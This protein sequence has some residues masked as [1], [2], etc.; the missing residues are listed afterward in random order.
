MAA[1]RCRWLVTMLLACLFA[2]CLTNR[3]TGDRPLDPLKGGDRS[4]MRIEVRPME[5]SAAVGKQL[6]LVATVYDENNKPK[7]HRRV[8]WKLEGPGIILAV[9]ESGFPF[10]RGRKEDSKSATGFT[11]TFEH[12]VP[13]NVENPLGRS[14]LPGQTWCVISSAVEGQT[15]VTAFVPDIPDANVNRGVVRTNWVDARWQFPQPAVARAGGEH[16][17]ATK[18]NR[19]SESGPAVGYRV[20]YY[21]LDDNAQVGLYLPGALKSGTPREVVVSADA[22]GLARASVSQLKPELTSNRIA[23]EILRPDVS[24]PGGVAVVARS[25]TK[26]DWQAPQVK[27]AI[28]APATAALNQAFPITYSISS[29]GGV[30]SKSMV[31]KAVVPQGMQLISTNPKA[32]ADGNE[33][34][35]S[36]GALPANQ[37]HTVQAV[38]RPIRTG[39]ASVT[40]NVRTD[41]NLRGDANAMIQVTE[42]RLQVQLTGPQAALV[43]ENVPYRIVVKNPGNGL[44]TNIRVKAQMDA[45]LEVIGKPGPFEAVIDKLDSGQEQLIPLPLSPRQAGRS[46]VKVSALADGNLSAETPTVGIDV[47]KPDLKVEVHGPPRGYLNQELTWTVRIFNPSDVPLSNVVVRAMLPPDITFRSATNEGRHQ[48]GAVEWNLGTAVGKQWADV[49]FTAVATKLGRTSVAATVSGAPLLKRGDEFQPVSMVKPFS[50]EKAET[51]LEILGIP[52][53][54]LE[55]FD[56][57]DPVNVGQKITYTIRITNAGTLPATQVNV[58][59]DLPPQMKPLGAFGITNGKIEGQR[60]VFPPV[61]SIRPRLVSVFT[62]EA[63]AIS[64]GDGRFRAEVKSLSLGSPITSEEATRILPKR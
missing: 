26:I 62:I 54:Q 10:Y 61:D 28:E 51:S 23:I 52:A 25:E 30:E 13:P 14:I 50:A 21:L 31:V 40:A 6:L 58:I 34:L 43:G 32:T 4:G 1:R 11:N 53:L 19:H 33:L 39:A 56:S 35:W 7:A 45:G 47:R 46:S 15:Y 9:D 59:A 42:A 5:A 44:A 48:N 64:E 57:T 17:L 8:E 55:V 12:D 29:T 27:I 63:Q 20:R 3:P 2:G 36:L 16:V 18:I 60:V 49:Q 37:Q 24:Q 41:D 22:E 38:Y